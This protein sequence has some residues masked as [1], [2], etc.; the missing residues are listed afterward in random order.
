MGLVGENISVPNSHLLILADP[1]RFGNLHSGVEK[2]PFSTVQYTL[3]LVYQSEVVTDQDHSTLVPIDG[4]S[5]GIDGLH[6]QV[7]G[8]LV[9]QQHVRNL[10]RTF[11]HSKYLTNIIRLKIS[12]EEICFK[13]LVVI[14]F[15]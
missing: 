15:L 2:M 3:Y 5:Q 13:C 1:D 6:V 9:Q 11:H 14:D 12:T 4:L 7:V 10:K 8:G